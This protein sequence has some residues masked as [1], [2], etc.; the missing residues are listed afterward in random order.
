MHDIDALLTSQARPA[1]VQ[2]RERL[3]RQTTR[4]IR[5]RRWRRRLRWPLALAACLA[6][7]MLILDAVRNRPE[8]VRVEIVRMST[9]AKVVVVVAQPAQEAELQ[10]EQVTSDQAQAYFAAGQRYASELGDWDSALRCYRNAL[11]ADPA[12]AE[13]IDVDNDDWLTL[14][15]KLDRQKEKDNAKHAN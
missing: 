10:A 15:L 5:V 14:A 12:Q 11:D 7:G 1:D 6:A 3:L 4:H 2:L 8:S 9:P 13:H